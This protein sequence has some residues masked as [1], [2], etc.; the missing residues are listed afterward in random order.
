MVVVFA[1]WATSP[2]WTTHDRVFAGRFSTDN[3]VSAWFYDFVSR[4]LWEGRSLDYIVDFNFPSPWRRAAEFPAV[5]DAVVAAPLGWILGWPG[6]WG[7]AQ[8]LAVVV[9]GLG[10]AC[11]ARAAGCRGAGI[12]VAGCLAVVCRPVWKDLV[13]A[14]MN[15]VWLGFCMM[16]LAALL[17]VIR[18]P[19]SRVADAVFRLPMVLLAAALGA[20]SALVYPPMLVLFAPFGAVLILAELRRGRLWAFALGAGAVGLG[21]LV[22]LPYLWDMLAGSMTKAI[23]CS[24]MGCPNRYSALALEAL[25]RTTTD[26]AEGLS[27][28]AVAVGSWVLAPLVLLSKRWRVG[29]LLLALTGLW[30][31]MALGPCAS[32]VNGATIPYFRWPVVGGWLRQAWCLS[33]PV[34]DYGRFVSVA[35]MVAAILGG[36]GV[37]GLT[38]RAWPFK[39]VGAGLAVAVVGHTQWM[40]LS[41]SLAPEKWH[42][43]PMPRTAAHVLSLE[44]GELGPV[45]ELPFDRKNQFLSTLW[46]PQVHRSNPLRPGDHPPVQSPFWEWIYGVGRGQLDRPA[47]QAEAVAAS[48]LAWV[49]YDENRCREGSVPSAACGPEVLSALGDVFGVPERLGL[50]VYAWRVD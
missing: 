1:L 34:H 43:V 22:A 46:A 35:V 9:N 49:Y 7:A 28:P 18:R 25:A 50:G 47:P 42:R 26:A 21:Y 45:I 40:V 14:R 13:S 37:E 10:A 30:A 4:A 3:A 36:V 41:E 15:A 27:V 33:S 11:L 20:L 23:T 38:R 48:G 24:D 6:Q 39:L 16:A 44:A 19:V 32:H 12:A 29:L 2:L 5:M 17:A 8:A 31:F